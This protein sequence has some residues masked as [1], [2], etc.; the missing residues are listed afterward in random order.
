VSSTQAQKKRI[1]LV[2]GPPNNGRDE[3]IAR[4]LPELRKTKKIGYYHVFDNM[5]QI[6][7]GCGIPNLKRESVF[8][9][10]KSKLDEIRDKAFTQVID[11]IQ[12]SSNDIDIVSTP[13]IFKTPIRA[14]Y[15]NG[16]VEG[17]NMEIM[18]K[19]NPTLLI[20]FMDDLLAVRKRVHEDTLTEKLNLE[21]KDIAE[22]REISL[23]SATD[24]VDE[25]K[26][27]QILLD[28][29]IFAKQH[30]ISTFVDLV[31]GSKPRIY[32]S[33]HIT[34]QDDFQ[35]ILRLTGKLQSHFVVMDPYAIKDWQIVKEYDKAIE[36]NKDQ[37]LMEVK[38]NGTTTI[39]KLSLKE[40][41]DAINLIRSQIVERD[42]EVIA[43]AHA[44]VVYHKDK[45]P[46]YG[47]MVEVFHSA[48]TVQRPVYVLYPFKVRLSPFF[49]HFVKS[50]N[51]IQG[52]GDAAKMEDVLVSKLVS[53]YPNWLT[54]S[55][56]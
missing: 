40:T 50:D 1:V 33:Y 20:F 23:E 19:L 16:I 44:T 31:L 54:W 36:E 25:A 29:M 2:T 27:R 53:E 49:E 39:E 18:R 24:Y 9:V 46:S 30:P 42:L 11:Q 26:A 12:K 22:W 4:A 7:S 15:Y 45:I 41:A 3:Y 48:T 14:D 37:I 5:K 13:S 56:P 28:F 21:L 52:A 6:S 10:S 17:L 51:I 47:V 43:N 8:D 38:T 35:D 34:G 55:P 32:L